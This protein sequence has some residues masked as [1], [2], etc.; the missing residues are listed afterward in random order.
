MLPSERGEG[1]LLL[2]RWGLSKDRWMDGLGKEDGYDVM[3]HEYTKACDYEDM[4]MT[5]VGKKR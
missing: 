2:G 3:R 5:A 1:L 4:I